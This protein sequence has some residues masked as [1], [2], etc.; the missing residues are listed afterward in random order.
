VLSS[1]ASAVS[2]C[3]CLALCRGASLLHASQSA[4]RPRSDAAALA[5]QRFTPAVTAA[6]RWSR[7]KFCHSSAILVNAVQD[8]DGRC[9]VA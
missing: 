6:I 9:N 7:D 3:G 4:E 2:V 8:S 5:R 1:P